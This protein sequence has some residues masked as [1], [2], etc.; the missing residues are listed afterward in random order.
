MAV[1]KCHGGD[2]SKTVFFLLNG[3]V[4]GT[5][6]FERMRMFLMLMLEVEACLQPQRQGICWPCNILCARS[7][8]VHQMLVPFVVIIAV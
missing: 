5:S 3:Y 8:D 6:S 2:H 7:H 4:S 1:L